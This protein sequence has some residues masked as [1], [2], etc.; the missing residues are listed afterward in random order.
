[1]LTY[2]RG[3]LSGSAAYPATSVR[4]RSMM[5]SVT[6]STM[7]LLALGSRTL[8]RWRLSPKLWQG[9]RDHVI[10][11]P[12]LVPA[13]D[14]DDDILLPV[15]QLIRHRRRASAARHRGLPEHAPR[16]DVKRAERVIEGR[17]HAH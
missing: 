7:N 1:M 4:G 17:S 14:T 16:P 15:R 6:T 10:A 5:I 13:A 12:E 2:H 8:L 3:A 11:V 9:E